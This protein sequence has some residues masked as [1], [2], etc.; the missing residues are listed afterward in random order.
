MFV[1][2]MQIEKIELFQEDENIFCV[3]AISDNEDIQRQPLQ[4]W[5]CAEKIEGRI[6]LCDLR[7]I[8]FLQ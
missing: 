3:S 7:K 6:W 1:N 5:C 4:I 2:E 8:V